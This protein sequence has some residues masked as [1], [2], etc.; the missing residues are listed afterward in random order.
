VKTTFAGD[1]KVKAAYDPLVGIVAEPVE[2]AM[3]KRVEDRWNGSVW[4]EKATNLYHWRDL[5]AVPWDGLPASD[6][7][8]IRW[9]GLAGLDLAWLLFALSK[10]KKQK[11]VRETEQKTELFI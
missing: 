5:I 9:Y 8:T 2:N 7:L 10:T 11:K 4:E 3:T 1:V 6:T